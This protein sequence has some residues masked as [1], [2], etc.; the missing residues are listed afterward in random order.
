MHRKSIRRV[1]P[2]IH[3]RSEYVLID[4]KR[5]ALENDNLESIRIQS[6]LY[7]APETNIAADVPITRRGQGQTAAEK[8]HALALGADIPEGR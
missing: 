2:H 7:M 5:A 6:T 1:L 4:E 8:V 3:Y